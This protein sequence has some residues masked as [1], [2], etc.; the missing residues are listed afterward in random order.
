M[1]QFQMECSA[2]IN[3]FLGNQCMVFEVDEWKVVGENYWMFAGSIL[4]WKSWASKGKQGYARNF[5][6]DIIAFKTSILSSYCQAN[7]GSGEKFFNNFPLFMTPLKCPWLYYM[8][9]FL[10]FWATEG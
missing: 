4:Y 5:L 9:I 7:S 3:T 1:E 8:I 6:Y 2:L 10:K